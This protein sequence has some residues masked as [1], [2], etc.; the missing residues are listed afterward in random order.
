[1]FDVHLERPSDRDTTTNEWVEW[2]TNSREVFL[3][4]D[5]KI[6]GMLVIGTLGALRSHDR[7]ESTLCIRT[8]SGK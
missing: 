1:M 6:D 5:E 7:G 4:L 3:D 8:R 2:R